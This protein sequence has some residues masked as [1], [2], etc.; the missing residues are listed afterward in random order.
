MKVDLTKWRCWQ[1]DA[2]GVAACVALTLGLVLGGF[3]PMARRQ[4]ESRAQQEQLGEERTQL[5]KMNAALAASQ[6][7]LEDVQRVLARCRLRLE[8]TAGMNH[9]LA[10]ISAFAADVGLKVNEIQPGQ[11]TPGTYYH[12]V[13]IH[14]TG[15]GTYRQCTVF[16][17]RLREQFPDTSVLWVELMGSGAEPS[18]MGLFR[19]DL[20]W[21]ASLASETAMR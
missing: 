15:N 4:E 3:R 21:H 11:A 18:G 8:S 20:Q 2:V 6:R 1:I 10:G 12:T 9:R 13:P 17:H 14:L 7:Q 19:I 16:L 5:A